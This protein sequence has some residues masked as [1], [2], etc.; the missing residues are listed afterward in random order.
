MTFGEEPKQPTGPIQGIKSFI[1]NEWQWISIVALIIS[2]AF[3]VGVNYENSQIAATNAANAAVAA[4]KSADSV[5][6]SLAAHEQMQ[7]AD[8]DTLNTRLSGIEK[9]LNQ[10]IGRLGGPLSMNN[11]DNATLKE[12]TVNLCFNAVCP[13]DGK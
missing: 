9:S 4:Q 3:G 12:A 1:N 2:V 13:A 11:A 6:A 8:N 5:A 10:L 7:I